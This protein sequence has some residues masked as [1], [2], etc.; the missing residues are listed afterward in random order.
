M[1]I[2]KNK[3]ILTVSFAGIVFLIMAFGVKTNPNWFLKFD[4]FLQQI[5]QQHNTFTNEFFIS[6]TNVGSVSAVMLVSAGTSVYLIYKHHYRELL[7]LLFNII[8]STGVITQVIKHLIK[9]P[10]PQ[11]Q[12]IL[13]SGYSFPSGHSMA[14]ILLYGSLI[15]LISYHFNP[16]ILKKLVW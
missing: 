13:E 12:L 8:I 15:V 4:Q 7:F 2:H 9:R 11:P 5:I 6:M 14:T 16:S 3:C 1:T 10:R